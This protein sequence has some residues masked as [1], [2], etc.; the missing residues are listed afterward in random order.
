MNTNNHEEKPTLLGASQTRL[1]RPNLSSFKWCVSL[2]Q[3]CCHFC[4]KYLQRKRLMALEFIH[5]GKDV[6]KAQ[7]PGM[8]RRESQLILC[9]FSLLLTPHNVI[10]TI[11]CLLCRQHHLR[12]ADRC[13]RGQTE[14]SCVMAKYAT[15]AEKYVAVRLLNILK[16]SRFV[17]RKKALAKTTCAWVRCTGTTDTSCVRA[18]CCARIAVCGLTK[19]SS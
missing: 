10:A 16:S 6:A 1:Q 19:C 7:P 11:R 9:H 12:E 14:M 17:C 15:A 3:R 5:A 13:A 8:V 18:T 2:G 4:S